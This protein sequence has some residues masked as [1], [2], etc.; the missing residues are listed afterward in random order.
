MVL[1]SY[2]M[3]QLARSAPRFTS[4]AAKHLALQHYHLQVAAEPLPGHLDRN[5]L[6]RVRGG[7]RFVLKIMNAA[8]DPGEIDL[9]QHVLKFLHEHHSTSTFPRVLQTVEGKGAAWIEDNRGIRH[10][11]WLVSWLPGR[12]LGTVKPHTPELLS[13]FGCFLGRM[14]KTLEGFSHPMATR[15]FFWDLRRASEL[16]TYMDHIEGT[17]RQ[18]LVDQTLGL[19]EEKVVPL[20]PS[21]K[22]S[23]IHNDANDF[24]VLIAGSGYDA[25]ICGLI[26]FGD[27][28]HTHTVFEIAIAATYVMLDKPDPLG[29]ACHVINGYN[30][31]NPLTTGEIAALF[32][33]IG[34]RLCSSVLV[35]AYRKTVEP[36]NDYLTISEAPAWALLE[37]LS[38]VHPRFAHYMFREACGMEPCPQSLSVTTWLRKHAKGFAAVTKPDL[39]DANV[40]IVD[41]SVKSPLA[42]VTTSFPAVLTEYSTTAI[43]RWDEPRLCYTAEG[44]GVEHPTSPERRTVHVGMDV[45]QKAGS[46]VFAPL[47]GMVAGFEDCRLPQ[48]YGPVL[49]LEHDAGGTP[50]WTLFGHLSRTSLAGLAIGQVVG[51]GEQIGTLGEPEENGG[52]VPHL[53]FQ[54]IIDLLGQRS[55]FPGVAPPSQRT[56]WRSICPD[57]N[58]ILGIPTSGFP[59]P[60]MNA[61]AILRL[62]TRHIGPALSLSYRRPLDIVRGYMQYLYDRMGRTY[63][64]AVNNVPHVGHSHPRVVNAAAQQMAVLNTNTRYLHAYLA[65]YAERLASLLPDPLSVCYFVNS[66][67]AANDLALRLAYAHTDKRN[68]VVLD[69]AYHGNLVSLIEISP[70]KFDGPGGSGAPP[71][72]FTATVPD[73]YR[74]AYRLADAGEQYAD[75]VRAAIEHAGG[76]IAAFISESILGCG[77]QIE[78]PEGYLRAVYRH[79]REAGGVCIADE[80]QVGFGRVGTHFWGFETQGVQPDIVVM[81]KPIGNGHPLGAVVTT[82]EIAASFVTGMEFFSTFG[83]NPVSCA[84]GMAVLDVLEDECLQQAALRTGVYLKRGLLGLQAEHPI[85]GDVRGRGLFLGVEFVRD[86]DSLEPATEESAYVTDRLCERG[87]LVSADGPLN[88]VLKIKPPLVFNEKDADILVQTLHE[89]LEEDFVRRRDY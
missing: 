66:G 49:L 3:H 48:D 59:A 64:D 45:F 65:R 18:A 7:D 73:P 15:E 57:P 27:V 2:P 12:V 77:G 31:A 14:D 82:P 42:S 50:F 26:D 33:L 1:R 89:I 78:F 38:R 56:V 53:H 52:W 85:V 46:P 23:V 87:I 20:L 13:D 58:L 39:R 6:L 55:N 9:Q 61:S 4:D 29:V 67:S 75:S 36:D 22:T 83:G 84:A 51:A 74:G 41:L 80:V 43:G 86:H 63:L 47:A 70:Y 25:R 19:Y 81:G 35:S 79:T 60:E 8:A 32:G 40:T 21:L 62:R 69:G 68:L 72:V 88:N 5:F 16:R 54:V 17:R 24:N 37:T 34:A 11:L 71:H 10:L 30:E 44:F 76:S 28:L